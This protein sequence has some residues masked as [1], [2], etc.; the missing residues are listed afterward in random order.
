MEC[1]H[2]EMSKQELVQKTCHFKSSC[3]LYFFLMNTLLQIKYHRL[4]YCLCDILEK[5]V[6]SVSYRL[7]FFCD[8]K[9]H[10]RDNLLNRTYLQNIPSKLYFYL[11]NQFYVKK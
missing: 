11:S 7:I 8:F 1:G 3:D 2:K 9:S 5:N 10:L 4:Q 6:N